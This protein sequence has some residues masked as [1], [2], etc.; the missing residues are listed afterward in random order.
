MNDFM[1]IAFGLSNSTTEPKLKQSNISASEVVNE[2]YNGI[3]SIEIADS[4]DAPGVSYIEVHAT[5]ATLATK[6][7]ENVRNSLD[8]VNWYRRW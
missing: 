8:T 3:M 6:T 1:W 5:N 2:T 7:W 4:G